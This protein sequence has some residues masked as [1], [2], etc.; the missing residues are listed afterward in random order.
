[1]VTP[2]ATGTGHGSSPGPGPTMVPPGVHH[3]GVLCW[4]FAT[5]PHALSSAPVGGGTCRPRW[6]VNIGVHRDYARTDLAA[7]AAEVAAELGLAGAGTALFTAADLERVQHIRHGGVGVSATVGVTS[8]TWAAD[9]TGG[10]TAWQPGTINIVATLPVRLLTGA[11]VSAVMTVTEAKTQALHEAG[12]PGTGT[13]SDAVAILC[14]SRGVAEVFGGPRSR[15][16]AVLAVATHTAV[17]AGLQD[18]PVARRP[19]A[20]GAGTDG[21]RS[22]S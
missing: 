1:M 9:P 5:P 13:A 12:V 19:G 2:G 18:H 4:R 20:Q 7:H 3:R 8:P 16:G 11:M 10:F 14:A 22:G 15:W 17:A 6:L 21:D